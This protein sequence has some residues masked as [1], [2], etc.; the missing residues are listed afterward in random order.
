MYVEGIG[1]C[2]KDIGSD[3][4]D[5]W[6]WCEPLSKLL[7]GRKINDSDGQKFVKKLNNAGK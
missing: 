2:D 4:K 7:Y 5:G 6:K 1:V 3:D